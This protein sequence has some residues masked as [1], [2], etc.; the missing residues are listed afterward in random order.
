MKQFISR[1]AQNIGFKKFLEVESSTHRRAVV[2]SASLIF[3]VLLVQNPAVIFTG[4]LAEF[5]LNT[6]DYFSLLIPAFIVCAAVFSLPALLLR[7]RVLGMY[8]LTISFFALLIWAYSNII[9]VN[10]GEL[11]GGKFDF[12]SVNQLWFLEALILLGVFCTLFYLYKNYSRPVSY[13]LIALNVL[14]G[15]TVIFQLATNFQAGRKFTEVD[16]QSI[17]RMSETKN[18]LIILMDQFQS[19]IFADLVQE[20]PSIRKELDGFT[21]FPDTLGVA[22]TTRLTMPSVHSGEFYE[23]GPRLVDFY[24]TRV[25]QGSFLNALSDSGHEVVLVS[26]PALGCPAKATLCTAVKSA[27]FRRNDLLNRETIKFLDYS[28]FRASPLA[29]K[30]I[31]YNDGDWILSARR[32]KTQ[33]YVATS[34][35]FLNRFASSIEV[36]GSK[37]ATKLIHLMSTHRPYIINSECK[38]TGNNRSEQRRTQ[39]YDQ[40]SCGLDI[41]VSVLRRLKAINA[42]DNTTIMLL[43]DTGVGA[44]NIGSTHSSENGKPIYLGAGMYGAANPVLLVKPM[45]SRGDY[46]VSNNPVQLTDIAATICDLTNDCNNFPGKPVFSQSNGESVRNYNM[47]YLTSEW[48]KKSFVPTPRSYAVKGP[49]WE[50]KSWP[51]DLQ[52]KMKTGELIR[53]NHEEH[54]AVYLGEGWG[55]ITVDGTFSYAAEAV[56]YFHPEE[57]LANAYEFT[58]TAQ[59]TF[60]ERDHYDDIVDVYANG[61][62]I[63]SWDYSTTTQVLEKKAVIQNEL[64]GDRELLEIRFKMKSAE[65]WVIERKNVRHMRTR[66]IRVKSV[67]FNPVEQ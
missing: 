44:F 15:V 29:G 41:F 36:S 31:F 19:D 54:N 58:V 51:D 32:M 3:L 21:F 12:S 10:F 8:A 50:L 30:R 20:N 56:M 4:N 63:G 42:Y 40:A 23:T 39:M 66:G 6:V 34:N 1:L 43:A 45:R 28:M 37:P 14:V 55:P 16:S 52:P 22:P 64:I 62:L 27:V 17:Y 60:A 13:F 53:F 18:V 49:L 25:E 65:S 67:Q 48:R 33:H 24:K 5:R 35:I 57:D 9:V 11:D 47:Y 46:T 59:N 61:Q 7:G 38:F 26:P 2:F